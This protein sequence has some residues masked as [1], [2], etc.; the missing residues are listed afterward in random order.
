MEEGAEGREK[1]GRTLVAGGEASGRAA[2]IH[3]E[4]DLGGK[5]VS[6][7]AQT[8]AS[9]TIRRRETPTKG[10]ILDRGGKWTASRSV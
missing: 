10:A 4:K 5:V 6:R 2:D 1:K 3:Q 9:K 8:P 7:S